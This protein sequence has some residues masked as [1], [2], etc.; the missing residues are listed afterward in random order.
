MRRQLAAAMAVAWL[1]GP[2][3]LAAES[4]LAEVR[5]TLEKWVQTRQ[6]ISRTK[7]DWQADREMRRNTVELL[8]RELK[9]VEAQIAG[10][11][12]N[13]AVVDQER[14]EAEALKRA[15][16]AALERVR[17]RAAE[18]E[19]RLRQLVPRLPQPLQ[20]MLAPLLARL[21]AD[22]A[23]TKLADTERVQVLV[24]I[25]NELDKFQ[26][27]V[28]LF[29]ERRKKPN[30]EEV[31]VE[32]VYIGLGAAYFVNDANDFAGL[33]A[34]G[35]RGWEWTVQPELAPAVRE[36]IR[37]YRNERTARFVALPAIIR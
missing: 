3:L 26:N 2:C 1:G 28:N 30:G 17:L 11:A 33:G 20:E 35:E 14:A 6:L 9:T 19:G 15:S 16:N 18:F 13:S 21:P 4:K 24:G 12:T 27:A 23:N 8:E 22:S 31:A 32:T 5:S 37:I 29:S 36:A 10:L 25:L 34:P 7:A